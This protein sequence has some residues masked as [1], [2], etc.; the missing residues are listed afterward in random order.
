M[1]VRLSSLRA[2]RPLHPGRFLVLSP[3][4]VCVYPRAIV[5]A[6]MIRSSEKSND[7]F[8]S[9]NCDLP[10]CSIV[11]Q[12]TTLLHAPPPEYTVSIS[13]HEYILYQILYQL[14]MEQIGKP[15]T[16]ADIRQFVSVGRY[17]VCMINKK[18][19]TVICLCFQT[20]SGARPASYPMD[21]GGSFP[22]G[23]ATGAWSW[24]LTSN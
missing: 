4:R 23:K 13:L 8:G 10:A 15:M 11:P 3:V 19:S 20:G 21:T 16:N 7:F 9:R 1:A 5:A 14:G 17:M 2:D 12:P 18:N 6:G 22:W 24:P